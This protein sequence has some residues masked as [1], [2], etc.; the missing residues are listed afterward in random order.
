MGIFS[1]KPSTPKAPAPPVTHQVDVVR[2]TEITVD[3]EWLTVRPPSPAANAAA[4][5]PATVDVPQQDG[6]T[7]Q[8]KTP[9]RLR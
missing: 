4:T 7:Q 1:R 2:R 6:L 8:N 5:D 3:E 9:R